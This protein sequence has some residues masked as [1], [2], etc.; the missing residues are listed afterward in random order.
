MNNIEQIKHLEKKLSFKLKEVQMLK[1]NKDDL[2]KKYVTNMEQ[3]RRA[4]SE[5]M[6]IKI[7]KKWQ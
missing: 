3:A 7:D 4:D 2:E 1:A 5:L 6:A